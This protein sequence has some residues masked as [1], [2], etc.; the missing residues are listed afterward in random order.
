VYSKLAKI[1]GLPDEGVDCQ[2]L[3]LPLTLTLSL[4]LREPSPDGPG[5]G[6]L[7][8]GLPYDPATGAL[9]LEASLTLDLRPGARVRVVNQPGWDA[10]RLGGATEGAV[11][12]KDDQ[13]NFLVKLETQTRRLGTWWVRAA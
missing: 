5:D 12:G 8:T 10:T 9:D 7:F 2:Q 1:L 11:L 6:D 13:G 4:P 3:S